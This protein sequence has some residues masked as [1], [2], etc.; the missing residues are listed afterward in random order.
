MFNPWKPLRGALLPL[1][2]L[3]FAA[4]QGDDSPISPVDDAPFTVVNGVKLVN[5]LP[6]EQLSLANGSVATLVSKKEG[7]TLET[8]DA[9]FVVQP[10]STKNNTQISMQAVA[11]PNIMFKFGPNG[12]TFSPAASL[13]IYAAKAALTAE[14]KLRLKVAGASDDVENWTVVGGTYDPITDSVTVPISHFSRYALC[15]E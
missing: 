14:Q 2:V 15:V 7:A 8:T 1:A 4:C 12:T 11:G 5:A 10:F 6:N 9:K 13:T 3:G